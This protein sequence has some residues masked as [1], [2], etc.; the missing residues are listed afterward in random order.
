MASN[1]S[2]AK[3]PPMKKT[4]PHTRMHTHW[5]GKTTNKIGWEYGI[6]VQKKR[7]GKEWN[8]RKW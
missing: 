5:V 7:N 2:N 4:Q 3:A 6:N 1:L 8:E